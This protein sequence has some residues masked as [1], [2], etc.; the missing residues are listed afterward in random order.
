MRGE[1]WKAQSDE[2]EQATSHL[3]LLA[4]KGEGK[5]SAGIRAEGG[6]LSEDPTG[7]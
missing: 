1:E 4:G 3:V 7:G 5:R 6:Q 2:E